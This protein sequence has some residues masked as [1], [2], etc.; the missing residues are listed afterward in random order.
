[1]RA[2]ATKLLYVTFANCAMGSVVPTW[3]SVPRAFTT[4]F[5]GTGVTDGVDVRVLVATEDGVAV[6]VRGTGAV[7]LG[8]GDDSPPAAT[9]LRSADG[10]DTAAT[11]GVRSVDGDASATT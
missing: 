6:T 3:V 4:A 11:T 7:G 2:L 8:T 10:E 9:G 5:D 1:M